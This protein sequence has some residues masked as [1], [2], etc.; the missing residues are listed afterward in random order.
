MSNQSKKSDYVVFILTHGR[1]DNVKTYKTLRRD[2]YTGPIRLVVDNLD[3]TVDM[4]EANFPNEVIVF[5]KKASAEK[6]DRGDNFEDYRAVVYAR[7]AAFGLAE[8]LGYEKFIVLDDDYHCF[9]YRFDQKNAYRPSSIKNLDSV[10]AAIWEFFDSTPTASI[11]M[12]Q[13]GDFIGGAENAYAKQVKLTRK[14]MNSFFCST[15]RPFRFDGTINEDVN[16]YTLYGSRGRLFFTTNQVSLDQAVTQTN[17]GGLTTIY[18]AQGTYVKSFYSVLF[19]PS[20]IC[21]RDM[22]DRNGRR[23]HHQVNWRRTVPKI[24]REEVKW[25]K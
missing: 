23:L 22:G 17:E 11:A 25:A 7:N 8:E 20:S 2:G 13:G 3:E 19:H 5:D 24:L 12:A 14:C 15:R 21:V 6:F 10:F 16:A 9:Q 18:L 1:A 4:Y